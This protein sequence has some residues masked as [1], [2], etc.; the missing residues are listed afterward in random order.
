MNV[1]RTVDYIQFFEGKD[2]FVEK[3]PSQQGR[4]CVTPEICP[5]NHECS[6]AAICEPLGSNQYRCSCI[7]GYIDQSPDIVNKPGNIL[8]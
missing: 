8:F 7:Q 1:S 4:V 3:S 2:G 6:S 5:S